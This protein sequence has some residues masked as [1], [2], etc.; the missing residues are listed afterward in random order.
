LK[1]PLPLSKW[2]ETTLNGGGDWFGRWYTSG[3][4]R[5]G[6]FDGLNVGDYGNGLHVGYFIDDSYLFDQVRFDSP[7]LAALARH[8][9]DPRPVVDWLIENAA[10]AEQRRLAAAL[11]AA[12]AADT[13]QHI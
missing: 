1:K 3:D 11:E 4:S 12:V 5:Y 9:D 10:T 13:E 6:Q 2:T 8:C 7:E